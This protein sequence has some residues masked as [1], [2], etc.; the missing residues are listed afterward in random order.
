M[1]RV[2]DPAW[3][4]ISMDVAVCCCIVRWSMHVSRYSAVAHSNGSELLGVRDE[5]GWGEPL[6]LHTKA[7][8]RASNREVLGFWVDT[9]LMAVSLQRRKTGDWRAQLE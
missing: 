3:V 1:G 8:P 9:G 7:T 2:E 4:S 6:L 5:G